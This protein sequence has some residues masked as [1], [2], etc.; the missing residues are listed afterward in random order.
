MPA[1]SRLY[2]TG[3][4]GLVGSA[5]A[6]LAHSRGIKVVGIDGDFRGRWFGSQ[7]S[8]S[9][10]IAELKRLGIR[11]IQGDFREHL[12]AVRDQ[13]AIVHCA[14]QPSH[15]FSR[16]H[17]VTDSA[18]NYMGT[19]QL[20]EA[21][22]TLAPKASFVFLSTNK[23]YG[24]RVNQ[25]NRW[26]SNLRY[27]IDTDGSLGVSEE[28]V[29]EDFPIDDSLHTPFGVSKLAADI[30]VQE[31][32][33]CFGLATTTL[34]CGCLT[35]NGGSPVEMQ[36][37]LG[38]LVRNAVLGLPYMIYGHKGYQVRDNLDATDLADAILR[39]AETPKAPIYNMGG[40]KENAV[41]VNEVVQHLRTLG[42]EFSTANGLPRLGDHAWWI[43][44]ASK[45]KAD[46]DWCPK[47]N[48]WETIYAMAI[49][50]RSRG[51]PKAGHEALST[52]SVEAERLQQ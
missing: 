24:D 13:D 6:E 17:V 26:K 22:R 31:Y 25:L 41:S 9:W 35:G 30:M 4:G 21:V 23:V 40:G 12:N 39:V 7:G 51:E 48:V 36:G 33:R 8:V 44:D 50:E 45:F 5:T 28:G 43:S 29:N 18:V 52:G 10:R 38:H 2:V 46:Y 16:S 32:R 1:L 37:F 14:S 47:R 27:E 3:I 34:R 11:V 42:C 19:V 15:D 49:A 20:L